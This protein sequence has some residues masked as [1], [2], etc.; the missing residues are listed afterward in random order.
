MANYATVSDFLGMMEHYPDD[1]PVVDPTADGGVI[2]V[3]RVGAN[4]IQLLFSRET[5]MSN[6]WKAGHLREALM[7]VPPETIIRFYHVEAKEVQHLVFHP[8]H[9]H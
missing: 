6:V 9:L 3:E 4:T 5:M 2:G 1:Y 8:K 7:A